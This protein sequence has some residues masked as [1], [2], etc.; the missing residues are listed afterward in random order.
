[1]L[2]LNV[3]EDLDA[4]NERVAEIS[5]IYRNSRE[6]LSNKIHTVSV[7]EKTG[8]QALERINPD[9]N[10]IPGK[11]AKFE[12]EYKRHGTQ[13]LISSFEVGTGRIIAHHIEAN[14]KFHR[15]L[16]SDNGKSLQV[17]L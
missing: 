15:I 2:N 10:A 3:I 12:F 6:N 1:M 4:F 13:A 17:D 16:Q 7:D 8:I 9:K 14:K 5:G 11:I